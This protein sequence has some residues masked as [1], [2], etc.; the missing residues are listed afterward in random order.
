MEH[1]VP[2]CLMLFYAL[3][4]DNGGLNVF[5]YTTDVGHLLINNEISG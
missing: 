5:Q 3:F 1:G 4:I 2:A